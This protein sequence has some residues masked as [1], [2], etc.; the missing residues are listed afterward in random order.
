MVSKIKLYSQLDLLNAELKSRLLPHLR[1]AAEGNNDFIFCVSSFNSSR[2]LKHKC[3]KVTE[4]LIEIGAQILTLGE[5]L[6]ESSEGTVAARVCWYCREWSTR[7][8][9]LRTSGV[10][11]AKKFLLEIENTNATQ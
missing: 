11:L 10:T 4:E 8:D 5:K 2:A 1:N 3:D 9:Q 6:G 7:H